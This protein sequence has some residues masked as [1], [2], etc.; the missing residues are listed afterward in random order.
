MLGYKRRCQ[1]LTNIQILKSPPNQIKKVK[2][3]LN[4]E[5][6]FKHEDNQEKKTIQ[7]INPIRPG[8]LD[9]GKFPGGG[10]KNKIYCHFYHNLPS[11]THLIMK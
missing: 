3:N 5:D 2:D 11:I 9:P 1:T 4:N 8:D 10:N 7:I 6:E